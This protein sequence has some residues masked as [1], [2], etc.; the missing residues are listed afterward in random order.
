MAWIVGDGFDYYGAGADVARSVWDSMANTPAFIT[1][2]N[3]R[4]GVGQGLGSL[5]SV[6]LT[7]TIGTNEATLYVTLAFYHIG[8]LSGTNP[9]YYVVF[10]DGATAQCTVVFES[11]GNIVLKSGIQ[12]G[13]VLATYTGAF[14]QDVWTH[15]QVRV[16]ISNT[17]G[18]MTVRKNGQSSDTY[19]SATTLNTRGGTANNYANVLALGA[20][21]NFVRID[22]VLC[23]SGSGAAPNDWVGDIRAITLMPTADTAQKQF[24]VFPSGTNA[25]AVDEPLANSDTDY[26][27]DSVVGHEDLYDM[28]NLSVTPAAV[29]G[30]VSKVF[31]KKSDAGARSGM[32]RVRSGATD[33]NGTDT[34]LSSTYTY[35][36]RV[37]T[38]DPATG[39]A[40]T[41]T[42]V[43][44]LQL[45]Q[46]VTA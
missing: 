31:I 1:G 21:S 12:T 33:V 15:F 37:D 41:P 40:W 13:T 11:S 8:V 30:V 32:L 9:D 38:T 4:F 7:K 35:L 16:V 44:A 10:R 36:S 23:Y 19:A 3:T 43:N 18:S 39:V 26:V 45:G 42:A 29:I 5:K 20:L 22:D 6:V 14:A 28:A 27:F 2:A 17:A 25:G 46:K 34:V 24:A